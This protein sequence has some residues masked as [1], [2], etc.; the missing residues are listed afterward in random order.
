MEQMTLVLSVILAFIIYLSVRMRK[1]T[2]SAAIAGA[3]IAVCIYLG[4]GLKGIIMLGTFFVLGNLATSWKLALK[5]QSGWA[6]N[7]TGQRN[8]CQVLANGSVAG[9]LGLLSVLLP[10]YH[11]LFLMLMASALASA[12]SDTM[13][14][15]LGTLYGKR[16]YNMLNFRPDRKGADG[17]ISLEGTLFGLCGTAL[18]VLVYV[19][20]MVYPAGYPAIII[21]AGTTG[22]ISDSL[23]GAAFERKGLV[24]NDTVNLLNTLVAAI[25][26]WGLAYIM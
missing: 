25:T 5:I 26:G 18:I 23:L 21:I 14:S 24:K 13:S 15:E 4:T 1:L 17:V 6:E 22:N 2:L 12:T 11:E 9:L 10:A 16:F 3:V 7:S 19:F 8:V 20:D